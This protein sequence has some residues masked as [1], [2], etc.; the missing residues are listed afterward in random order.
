MSPEM[1][2][3]YTI[4]QEG[5]F[6]KAAQKLY[7]TQPALS[8]A[9]RKVEDRIGMPLFDRKHKPLRLTDAGE[10]YIETVRRELQLEREQQQ[11]FDDIKNLA[12]GSIRI[13]GTHYINAYILPEALASFSAQYPGIE[14]DIRESSARSIAKM[15]ANREIDVTFNCDPAFVRDYP[16]SEMFVDHVLLAVPADDPIN[17]KYRDF[18]LTATQVVEGAH[19][20]PWLP[21]IGLDSFAELP[22]ILLRRGNNLYD[23]CWAMFHEVN[24]EP[25]VK[26][27]LNQLVTAYHLAE[28]GMGAT[29][30]SDRIVSAKNDRLLYYPLASALAKRTFYILLP[31]DAYVPV[32]VR[33]LVDHIRACEL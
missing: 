19:L 29:F 8:I 11:K 27:E 25:V 20:D 18:V 28:A 23:R 17:E 16:R 9:V 2:Y 14:L 30:V 3:I 7:L 33:R 26:M 32:A 22:L 5:S 12:T 4:W 21:R 13:G 6:S 1:Q 10:I 15:L 24:V 31:K